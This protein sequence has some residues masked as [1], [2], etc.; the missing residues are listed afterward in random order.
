MAK[1]CICIYCGQKF[2]TKESLKNH[3]KK[4]GTHV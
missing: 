1:I 2:R 3:M 4:F